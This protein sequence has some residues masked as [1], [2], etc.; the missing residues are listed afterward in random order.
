MAAS[1]GDRRLQEHGTTPCN[2][3]EPDVIFLQVFLAILAA[4]FVMRF[5]MWRRFR[6]F[7]G[8]PFA[9]GP[10]HGH[11]RHGGW[12]FFRLYRDLDLTRA[13]REQ[14]RGLMRELRE[15]V[16]DLR[17]DMPESLARVLGAE[18]FDRLSA[19]R[20]ADERVAK[21]VR[22]KDKALDVL[23]RVHALLT[24]AQRARVAAL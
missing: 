6:R 14:L 8:P 20:M 22:A 16:G 12:R 18:A 3:K 13:Q 21:L 2:T 10:R 23:E 15:V 5:I 7:G 11:G 4:F 1:R 17:G 24:P 9:F 19:E